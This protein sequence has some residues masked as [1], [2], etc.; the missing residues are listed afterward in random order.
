MTTASRPL[1]VIQWATGSVGRHA[2]PAILADPSLALAGVWVHTPAKVG[3]DA[4]ELVGLPPLGVRASGSIDEVLALDADCV[5]YAPLLADLDEMCRILAS[6]KNLVTP[7]GWVYLKD[8]AL[9]ERIEDACREGGV[10]FHGTGIHPGFGGDRLPLVVSA[11]SRRIDRIEVAEICDLSNMSESPQMIFDQLGFGATP[12]EARANPPALLSVMSRI[13]CE[14]MDMVAAGLGFELDDYRTGYEFAL[15]TRDVEIAAGTIPEGRVAGQHYHYTG[16]VRGVPMIAFRTYWK[17]TDH[18]EP[19]WPYDAT[20]EYRVEIAGDPP[21]RCSFGPV[22]D[23][24][25]SEFGLLATAMN[26]VNAI[27]PV[28]HA[29]PGIRTPLDLPLLTGRGR[30][31]L[32]A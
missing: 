31:R 14:S 18:M 2:I 29:P 25:S 10:S 24:T 7:T 16:F 9:V 19:R 22:T 20:L 3:R 30:V 12:E 23:G 11:L 5:L 27:A 15:A 4:G 17:M 13:F 26:C 21:L 28:C 8:P 1:R 32:P 6:G